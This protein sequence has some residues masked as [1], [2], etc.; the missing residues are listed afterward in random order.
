MLPLSRPDSLVVILGLYR[1]STG[2][3]RGKLAFG[4]DQPPIS[5]IHLSEEISPGIKRSR[6]GLVF[7]H[8]LCEIATVAAAAAAAAAHAWRSATAAVA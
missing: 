8:C 4:K 6:H 5:P 3:K 1:R 2:R 7:S